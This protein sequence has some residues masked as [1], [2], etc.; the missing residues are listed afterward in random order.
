MDKQ[1]L[2]M[3][4][5]TLLVRYL[6]FMM[7]GGL[8]FN[9]STQ[10]SSIVGDFNGDCIVDIEDLAI[11][12]SQWLGEPFNAE[13]GLVAHW[14]L[15]ESV[16]AGFD[17]SGS[18][19]YAIPAGPIWN[20]QGGYL[21][22]ALQFD[23]IDDYIW[24]SQG[25]QGVP[26]SSPRSCTAWVK[27][28]VPQGDIFAWG[29]LDGPGQGWVVRIDQW[30]AIGVDVGQGY[31]VGSQ[32][33]ADDL[34]HHI[35][36]TFDGTTTDDITLYIDGQIETISGI[37]SCPVNTQ[38]SGTVKL[39]VYLLPFLK[40]NFFNGLIDEARIYNRDLTDNEVWNLANK[41]STDNANADLNSDNKVD[42]ADFL[43]LS[44]N[45][46]VQNPTIIISEF[47]ANN[48]SKS[49][50]ESGEILDGN[51]Q[52]SDWLELH[53]VSD[54]AV[55]LSQLYLTDNVNFK[56]KWQFPAESGQSILPPGGYLLIFASG[57]TQAEN[58][59]NYP[60]V[61]SAGYLHTN[62]KLSSNGEY[63]ALIASDG[64]NV[65]HEYSHFDLGS[66][67]FGY[68]GQEENISYGIYYEDFRYFAEPTPGKANLNSII[69]FTQKPDMNFKGGCYAD[70]VNLEITCQDPESFIIYTTDRSAPSLTNGIVYS[71]SIQLDSLTTIIAKS[72]R[73]GYHS[74]DA[75]IETYI[76][77][78]QD[79][80]S[81]NSNL[82]IVVL[83]T[84][85]QSIPHKD[86]EDFD[87]PYTDCRAVIIDTD[88]TTGRSVITGSEHFAGLGQIRR[89]G[90]STYGQGH[91]AFEIQDEYGMDKE[92]SILGMPAESDWIITYDTIDNSFLKN[93]V[94][95]NWFRNMGHYAPRQRY[96]EVYLNTDGGKISTS[97]F[98]GLF[99][100]REKIKRNNDRV[101]IARLDNSHNIEPQVS[102]GYIIKCDKFNT[103][104]TL[105]ADVETEPYSI[106]T[107]GN[108][109]PILAEP[110]SVE[111]TQPQLDWVQNYLS[112]FHSVLWQN[113]DS[114]FYPG[115]ELHYSD[116][117]D[118]VS[119]IDHFIVEQTGADSDAFWGS[120][121]THKDR[122]G[123]IYSGPVWDFDR[124]FHNN[125]GDYDQPYTAWRSNTAIFG[126]WHL[127]LQKDPE[128]RIALAD[129]WFLHRQGVLGTDQT[130]D[131]INQTVALIA[132]ARSRPQTKAYPKSFAEETN[133]FKNWVTSRLDFMDN[134]IANRFA[135]KPPVLSIPSGYI[136][137]NEVI[138]I[139]KPS[140]VPGDIYYTLDGSDPRLSGGAINPVALVYGSANQTTESL[141]GM[142]YSIWKYLYDGSDQGTAW[143]NLD[144]DDSN[145][146]SGPGQLGFGNDDE[147]TYIGPKVNYQFTAYFR[148]ILNVSN[149]N[150]ITGLS[151]DLLYD[152][153]AVI[154]INGQEV[155]RIEMPD[156]E[157]FYDT[158]ANGGTNNNR[159]TSFAVSVDAL[160][161]GEN[162][163]AVEVHQRN[164]NS[165][166]ISFDLA[167]EVIRAPA[168]QLAFDK[169]TCLTARIKDGS[170]WSAQSK[171][172]YVVGPV[173]DNLRI[174]E[175]MYH[176]EDPNTE[177]IELQNTGD[178][179]INLNLVEFTKGVDFVIGDVALAPGEYALIVEN[180]DDFNNKYDMGLNVIGQYA[181]RLD[182]DGEHI[183]FNDPLGIAIQSFDYK[184]SWYDLTDGLGFSLTM[185]NPSSH[186]LLDWDSKYG[187]RSS[188][189]QNG[190]PGY[191]DNVLPANSIVINELL[192]H[193]HTN[194]PDW[195]ELY[196]TTD[197]D[198]NISG[199]FLSDSA[200]DSTIILK[201]EFPINTIIPANGY[202]VLVQDETFGNISADG[203]HV[204]FAFSEAGETVYLYSGE[205]GQV[206]GYYQ[207]QQKFDA[208]DTGISLGRYEKAELSGGYD[209]VRMEPTKGSINNEPLLSP[210][211]ITEIFYKPPSGTAYEFIELYN[212]SGSAIALVTEVSTEI[213]DSET[214]TEY[215]SWRIEGTGYEFPNNTT[216]AAG[217]RIILA[218]DP[219]K[220][221]SIPCRCFGP[222]DGEL[223][224][225]GEE[226]E[227]RIPGDKEF[228]KLRYWIPL[229][230]IEY[231]DGSHPVGSDPWP[232][233]A[234]GGGDALHRN[235]INIYGRDYSNWY[236][237]N[238]T[239]GN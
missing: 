203:C 76:F 193:S 223:D 103:G 108:G 141:I 169:S 84:L 83:D 215:I 222:Y 157:I 168:G 63:L 162:V 47:L 102:G 115:S 110:Q 60:Y 73:P 11:T 23:G 144:F 234:D 9:A 217:E 37:V 91:Y 42:L 92:V 33:I 235:N 212:R 198:I 54:A 22:G 127:E 196:N 99:V 176:P 12:T 123:K 178:E 81:F 89:R 131:H 145:W 191:V 3:M 202:F 227:I 25:Y 183:K 190:T 194:D 230:K 74:S 116:Y 238:P 172:I 166:D 80:A 197:Q 159:L 69:G 50:L 104:D 122:N 34:W 136:N 82:P 62:F 130:L 133:L 216:I 58:P 161:E 117:V 239:P 199:W 57:K 87:D 219:T 221:A 94:A 146:D 139:S 56:T 124:G 68:P 210:I 179:T 113:E 29:N 46:N 111:V 28:V 7:V 200:I 142:Q 229:E 100:V 118:V 164:Y 18:G 86:D 49:P 231:S 163:M 226:L 220:Y 211:V 21:D 88:Q 149:V 181:G 93:E 10:G 160:V 36:V 41:G 53:N 119:W 114:S 5:K 8:Y 232:I 6:L 64:E 112:E 237:A 55:D 158:S 121:Y 140:G 218:K 156:G 150:E 224:N 32:N 20:P 17:S 167:L 105:L 143:R 182:N 78:E 90:E 154:Y 184:D 38:T 207:T 209:F 195:I 61:D 15:D 171:A 97:D 128:Y 43:I 120:Y 70:A 126:S 31:V 16:G 27:A 132:E 236:A 52:S 85:G 173:A 13:T 45:W 1:K 233:S 188:L 206:N 186:D 96:V 48:N 106:H 208:S 177:F 66:D 44:D 14:K 75:R 180:I 98:Q 152:D 135:G 134:E 204:P 213:S 30:G 79:V 109:K 137:Q 205:N 72:F 129:R 24:I 228:D 77:I 26:G 148:H 201:Y 51:N 107:T 19:L 187:W 35:A 170:N 138:G 174:S 153:G 214:V 67:E 2:K 40:G 185:V 125:G 165:S 192:A 71:G 189:S 95:F 39:G 65:I 59:D 225:G 151:F 175:L 4:S 101:D 155:K 147:D